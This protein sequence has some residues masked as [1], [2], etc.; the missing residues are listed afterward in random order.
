[1]LFGVCLWA[2]GFSL[3]KLHTACFR[4]EISTSIVR[5]W[6]NFQAH[7]FQGSR[8]QNSGTMLGVHG[9][10]SVMLGVWCGVRRFVFEV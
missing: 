9:S 3:F 7:G 10:R 6:A 1:M 2:F 5:N 4:F 8:L